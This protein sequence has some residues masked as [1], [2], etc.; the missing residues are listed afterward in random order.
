MYDFDNTANRRNTYSLKW[1]VKENELPMWVADMDFRCAPE[2]FE[3]INE[4][5]SIGAL[6]YSNTPNSYFE[7]YKAFWERRHNV[8]YNIEDMVFSTGVVPSLSSAVRALTN[9]GDGV[10]ILTPV[11]NIFFNS[12]RNNKR[13][14]IECPLI[15]NS[16]GTYDIDFEAFELVAQDK[17]N[18][19]LIFC[20]P[21]NPT[22]RIW[23]KDEL[24]RI[25]DICKK[26]NITVV[27]DEIHCDIIKEGE[28]Y[29]PF[30][31]V[32]DVCKDI[33][34]TLISATKCFNMAGIQASLALS[35]NKEILRRF[36]RQLNTDEC[37]EGNFICYG[38]TIAALNKGEAWLN[39]MNKYV[40]NNFKL[41]EEFLKDYPELV[42]TKRS[43]TYLAWLNI[44]K[45]TNESEEFTKFLRD[46]TGLFITEGDEYGKSGKGFVRINLAT[47][48]ANILDGLN[49]FKIGV[50]LWK[51]R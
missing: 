16:N 8:S 26:N 32:N 6:G 13:N 43:A 51:S 29:I 40:D 45:I 49:R 5:L 41:L 23:T 4:R 9:I 3:A 28:E 34:L 44:S 33:S 35:S 42:L 24:I 21:G 7:A 14:I 18:T 20:N 50:K 47:S 48:K 22:G 39:E 19:M 12:I 25:G 17:N 30:Y 27:S 10:I 2:I 11:Y 1:D 15:Y 37:A 31:S 38:A 36:N 46:K